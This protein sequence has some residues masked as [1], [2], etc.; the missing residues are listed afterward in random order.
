MTLGDHLAEEELDELIRE[1]DIEGM[2]TINYEGFNYRIYNYYL[3]NNNM[4]SKSFREFTKSNLIA[5]Y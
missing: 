5:I 2:G 1:I 3:F 4:F